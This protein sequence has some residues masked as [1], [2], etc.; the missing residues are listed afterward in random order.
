[1]ICRPFGQQS[2]G[3]PTAAPCAYTD[4]VSSRPVA[5]VPGRALALAAIAVLAC[6]LPITTAAARAEFV[7]AEG[8]VAGGR[9]L[10][11]PLEYP[12]FRLVV[13]FRTQKD[14]SRWQTSNCGPATLG[15]IFD[16]F[17]VVDQATDDLRFRAHTY[18]G[19]VGM[20]TGTGLEH[21]AHVAEDFGVRAQ[22]LYAAD[23]SFRRW[24]VADVDAEL[25]IGHPVM[26]LVRL[27]LVPGYE[28]LAPRWGHYILLTGLAPAGFYFS[29]SLKTD[30]AAGVSGVISKAQLAGAM[31]A[32]HIPGQ[33]VA[34]AGPRELPV[35]LPDR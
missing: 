35:W 3:N 22:G 15:M 27:Y 31:G 7:P 29:D 32:S 34:F 5:P 18:Q 16:A 24:D 8:G 25:R 33:A 17:G 9:V 6:L 12:V 23:G 26:P 2:N 14:G 13:P 20:R 10:N 1:V 21:V 28:G 19:T 11:Q 4:A 30:P